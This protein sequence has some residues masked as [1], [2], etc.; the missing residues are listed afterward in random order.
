M[1]QRNSRDNI[2]R[3]KKMISQRDERTIMKICGETYQTLQALP[4]TIKI[5]A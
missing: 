1:L 2:D 3:W 4:N 5:K